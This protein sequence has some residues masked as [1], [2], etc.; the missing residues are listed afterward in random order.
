MLLSCSP[1][2]IEW[3]LNRCAGTAGLCRLSRA[4]LLLG[5]VAAQVLQIVWSD[6]SVAIGRLGRPMQPL[7]SQTVGSNCLPRQALCLLAPL[8]C[9]PGPHM[10][11]CK[12]RLLWRR[13]LLRHL[14]LWCSSQACLLAWPLSLWLLLSMVKQLVQGVQHLR[15]GR[16]VVKLQVT[17]NM[18][19]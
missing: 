2:P 5:Q 6:Q 15:G 8:C 1:K 11:I 10:P 18:A 17:G 14:L 4:V 16:Q 3:Y 9:Q 12:L 7:L 19:S 13:H